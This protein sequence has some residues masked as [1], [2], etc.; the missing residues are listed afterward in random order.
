[1]STM[2]SE[3][4]WVVFGT[5]INSEELQEARASIPGIDAHV[6]DVRDEETIR[7]AARS[8]SEALGEHGSPTVRW[9]PLGGA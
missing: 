9:A 6:V 8:V 7:E 3:K 4:G 1:M 5:V 2:R